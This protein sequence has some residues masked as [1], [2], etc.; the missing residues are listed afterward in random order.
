[1]FEGM[2][3]VAYGDEQELAAPMHTLSARVGEDHLAMLAYLATLPEDRPWED[4]GAR[5]LTHWV[6]MQLRTSYWRASRLL[7]AAHALHELPRTRAALRTGRLPLESVLE[8]ARF[9]RPCDEAELIAWA[10]VRSPST[11]RHEAERRARLMAEEVRDMERNRSARWWFQDGTFGLEAYLP[12]AQ[13]ATIAR[14]LER[15]ADTIPVMP[16]EEEEN[17]T[18]Q[19]RA[20]ALVALC[21]GRLS[22]DPDPD[23]ATVVV[24]ARLEDLRTEGANAEIEGGGVIDPVTVSRL[25]CDARVQTVLLDGQGGLVEAAQVRRDPPPWLVRLVRQRDKTCRFPGCEARRYTQA[26]HIR[27]WSKGGRTKL[28]N[29]AL[30]C[31]VHHRVVHEHGWT[32]TRDEHGELRWFWPDGRP[33]RVGHSPLDEERQEWRRRLEETRIR[34]GFKLAPEGHRGTM[35]IPGIGPGASRSPRR[36]DEATL[37]RTPL[38]DPRPRSRTDRRTPPVGLPS[39][40]AA[41]PIHRARE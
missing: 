3:R 16:G 37:S 12:A 10:E 21:A 40:P 8:L 38:G 7:R 33:H 36:A 20:D 32:L 22:S 25:L 41:A 15:V 6:S 27:F 30:L 11:I 35:P 23:R 18:E 34:F 19:R 39:L 26:H 29:L 17:G 2:G 13:G 1:M 31:G 4:W 5:N 9:A 28:S 24:H 14:A